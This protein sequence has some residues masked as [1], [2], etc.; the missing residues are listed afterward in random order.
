[1]KQHLADAQYEGFFAEVYDV[2]H[3]YTSDV[4][5]Y[6]RLARRFK[7]PALELGAGT[8]RILVHL[9]GGG[10]EITGLDRSGAMLDVCREK[11]EWE[12]KVDAAR[13]RL[14]RGDMRD[15]RLGGKYRF[16]FA[17]CDTFNLNDALFA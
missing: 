16:I 8:G 1:M 14:E 5:A 10:V 13:V 4:K 3:A 9:A 17:A 6:L 7:G 11:L 15:F 2:I 12:K